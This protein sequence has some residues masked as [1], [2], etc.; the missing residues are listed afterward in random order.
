MT[1]DTII[2]TVATIVGPIVAVAVGAASQ[3]KLLKQQQEYDL[4]RKTSEQKLWEGWKIA[5]RDR[6][7]KIRHSLDRIAQALEAR[8]QHIS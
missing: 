8:S 4:A 5:E 7:N 3:K 6:E 1:P 2:L